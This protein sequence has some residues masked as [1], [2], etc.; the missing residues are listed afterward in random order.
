M[1]ENRLTWGGFLIRLVMALVLV[2]A[3]YNPS[4][5]SY[6]HW[7][8]SSLPDAISALQALCGVM[9]LIGWVMF[10]RAGRRSL[11]FAGFVL[12]SAFFATLFWL[13][14]DWGLVSADNRNAITWL[15]EIMLAGMLAIGMSW[16]H[17]RRRMSGQVDVDETEDNV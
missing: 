1:A 14:L 9:L 10:I 15:V 11:G 6:F 13:L 16:S 12:A 5:Y 4:G 3:S 2:L 17:V 8:K 7:L